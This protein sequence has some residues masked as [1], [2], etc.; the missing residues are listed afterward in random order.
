M[1][2]SYT[3]VLFG[4]LLLLA[5]CMFGTSFVTGSKASSMAQALGTMTGLQ[6]AVAVFNGAPAASVAGVAGAAFNATFFY[7]DYCPCGD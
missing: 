6:W 5:A 2:S 4:G 7:H 3:R 1:R